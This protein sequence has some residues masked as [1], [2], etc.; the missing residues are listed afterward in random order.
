MTTLAF[1][2]MPGS[3]KTE[4]VKIA[5]NWGI[6]VVRMGDIIWEEV[7]KQ[8]FRITDENVGRIASELRV[9]QGKDIW[10]QRTLV[11]INEDP[12]I[13][14]GVRSYEEVKTFKNNLTDFCL[15]AIHAS[16]STR[17]ERILQRKR[18]DDATTL[19]QLK[20]RDA[21]ELAWGIGDVIAMADIMFI[22]EGQLDD[23]QIFIKNVIKKKYNPGN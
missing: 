5:H 23:L 20:K 19:E 9:T 7:S 11:Q 10:A 13:I 4:A 21:R 12:M 15:V 14:D 8:G 2:G 17:Y 6:K 22:N 1:T 3:G 18:R 16:P